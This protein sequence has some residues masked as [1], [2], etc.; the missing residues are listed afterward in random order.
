MERQEKKRL[1]A[2]FIPFTGEASRRRG[3]S[4]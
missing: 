3:N 2:S 4:C 1:I